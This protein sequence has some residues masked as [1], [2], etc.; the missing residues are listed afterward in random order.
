MGGQFTYIIFKHSPSR[1]NLFWVSD[2]EYRSEQQLLYLIVL[3]KIQTRDL[4]L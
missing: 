3:T 1:Q 2:V 4:W